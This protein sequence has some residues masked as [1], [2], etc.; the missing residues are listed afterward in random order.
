MLLPNTRCLLSDGAPLLQHWN[1][2]G[3]LVRIN[4]R[5]VRS[6]A[7]NTVLDRLALLRSQGGV[8]APGSFAWRG[9][10]NVG[11][12][13]RIGDSSWALAAWAAGACVASRKRAAVPRAVR[14]RIFDRLWKIIPRH[15][16][17]CFRPKVVSSLPES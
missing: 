13:S 16:V 12:G 5:T 11:R 8:V 7:P 2:I 4:Q 6:A 17:P 15:P 1:G 14:E 9:A 3:E 10:G